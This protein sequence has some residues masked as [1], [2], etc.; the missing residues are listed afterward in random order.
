MIVYLCFME[1]RLDGI[2]K[3]AYL[4]QGGDD[5][6]AL[7]EDARHLVSDK[8]V[9]MSAIQSS[10]ELHTSKLDVLED[11]LINIEMNRANELVS[12][13]TQWAYT[14]NRD[15]I[16]EIITYYERNNLELDALPG[17]DEDDEEDA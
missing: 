5:L 16:V 3:A 11:T 10:H 17:T 7:S 4:A 13:H 1:A 14:R 15:R 8:D 9:L 6:D 2:M 12:K